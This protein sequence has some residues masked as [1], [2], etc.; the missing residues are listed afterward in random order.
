MT[1]HAKTHIR[2]R[3]KLLAEKRRKIRLLLLALVLILGSGAFLFHKDKF[4][5]LT[6]VVSWL[7]QNNPGELLV[8]TPSSSIRGDIYDRN[9]RPLTTTYKTY[10]IYARPLE[11][12]NSDS[13]ATTLAKILGLEK[14]KLLPTLKSERG[15]IWVA[16][17]I[18]QETADTI[19][20]LNIRGVYQVVEA[21]RFYPNSK[22]AAHVVGFVEND[23]GLDGI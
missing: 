10:A 2:R 18:D 21:K 4:Y 16:Q 19:E 17:G 22:K 7:K 12:V 1:E 15:F 11:M 8:S 20:Q 9:F 6:E 3:R 14:N 5:A 13:S 23:Q